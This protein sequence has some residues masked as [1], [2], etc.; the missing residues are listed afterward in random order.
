MIGILDNS[1]RNESSRTI[2]NSPSNLTIA[3]RKLSKTNSKSNVTPMK[4]RLNRDQSGISVGM[5]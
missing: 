3:L 4:I 5:R 2:N 1:M